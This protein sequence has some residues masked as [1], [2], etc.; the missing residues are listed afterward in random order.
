MSVRKHLLCVRHC[1]PYL[2]FKVVPLWQVVPCLRQQVSGKILQYHSV[3]MKRIVSQ[4]GV[5]REE[6]FE[7]YNFFFLSPEG[8]KLEPRHPD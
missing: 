8:D 3:W 5:S 1:V 7:V 2:T 6:S 4:L